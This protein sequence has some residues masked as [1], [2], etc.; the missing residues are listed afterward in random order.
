MIGYARFCRAEASP[1]RKSDDGNKANHRHHRDQYRKRRRSVGNALDVVPVDGQKW[2]SD[3]F[4]MAERDGYF[5]GC[6]TAD[7][8]ASPLSCYGAGVPNAAFRSSWRFPT[9]KSA[10]GRRRMIDVVTTENPDA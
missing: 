9:G 10:S 4:D 5:Y 6:G 3:P 1:D 7:T 8:R 2:S